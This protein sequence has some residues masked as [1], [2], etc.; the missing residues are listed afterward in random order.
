[1]IKGRN[2]IVD[3]LEGRKENFVKSD[4]AAG[5]RLCQACEPLP[6]DPAVLRET[7]HSTD[8]ARARIVALIAH[9]GLPIGAVR[10][11]LPTH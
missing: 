5:H 10:R 8:S 7:P 9:H 1:M 2:S 11:I 4:G 6:Q 3:V